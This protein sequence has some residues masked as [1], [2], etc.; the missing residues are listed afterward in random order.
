[1]I[2]LDSRAGEKEQILELLNHTINDSNLELECLIN[3]SD[4]RFNPSIKHNDFIS[5]LKRYKGRPDFE[6]KESVRLA[7]DFPENSKYKGVRVLVKGLGAVNSYCNNENINLIR[8]SVD[9]EMKTKPKFKNTRVTIPNYNIKFNLKLE[10]NFNN[11]DAKINELIRD[12]NTLPKNFR[13][14]KTFSFIQKTKD[15]QIDLSIV[16]SSTVIDRFMTV[17]D[18]LENNWL[19]YVTKPTDAK[20]SFINWWNSIKDKPTEQVMLKNAS[21]YHKTV[22]ESAV[23]TNVPKYEAEVEYIKNKEFNINKKK[24]NNIEERKAYLQ[25]EFVNFFKHIGSILQC[26]Q[27]S[28]NIISN[29][30]KVDIKKKFIKVVLDSAKVS[31]LEEEFKKSRFVEKNRFKNN[32]KSSNDEKKQQ[33]RKNIQVKLKSKKDSQSG[34]GGV[35]KGARGVETLVTINSDN[36]LEY[37]TET[38]DESDTKIYGGGTND[39]TDNITDDEQDNSILEGGAFHEN[40]GARGAEALVNKGARGAEAFANKLEELL[41]RKSIFFGPL[42]VD[43]T[44]NNAL[45]ID[46]SAIPDAKSNTNIHINYLVTD[47]TDGDR[48]L[49]F[50]DE[51]GNVYGI[52][53]E[54]GIKSFGCIM[55]SL[56]NS[57]LDGEYISRSEEDKVINNF[58]I[59]DSY[60]YKG[61]NVMHKPFLFNKTGGRHICMIEAAKYAS[62]GLNITQSNPRLPFILYKKDYLPSDSPRS[63]EKLRM[64]EGEIPLISENCSKLL[65]RMNVKYG[66]FLEVGHLYTYKT[67]GLVFLPNNLGIFQK[68]EDEYVKNPFIS[69]RWDNNYKWKPADHLTIDFKVEY[70]KEMETAKLAYKYFGDKKYLLVNLLSKVW[71]NKTNDNN[72][73]NFYLLNSGL[74]L[75]S[76][77]EDFKFFATNPFIGTYDSEGEFQNNMGEA[78]FEVDKNDNLVCENGDIITNGILCECAYDIDNER[79]NSNEQFRWKPQRIRADKTAA[80]A[81]GTANAAWSLINDPIT[82]EKLCCLKEKDNDK[83]NG[84]GKGDENNKGNETITIKEVNLETATYYTSNKNMEVLTAPLNDFASYVKRYLIERW[85][86]GYIKPKVMDL[87][88]G[89]LGD[90]DKYTRAEVHTLVGLDITE[91]GINNEKDGAA[92][93]MMNVSANNPA[94]AKLAEKTILLVGTSV[95]NIANGDCVRDNINKYYLDV[96]YGRAKGNTPKLKKMAGVALD[97]FDMITCMYAIHYMMNTESDLDSFLQN[98]SENLLDQG[99]FIGTCLDGMSILKEMGR[100]N[101]II[102]DIDGKTVFFIRKNDDD[103][104]YKDITVGNKI[105]VFYEK[106][107]GYFPENLVNI[108]YLKEK[109]KGHNLKLI[110]FRTFLEEPGN[111]LSQ[112]A[113]SNMKNERLI[114]QS[115]AMMTWAKFNC[116]FVFQK[117]RG[118]E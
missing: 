35:D 14:K 94:V 24:F 21:S 45:Q 90:L 10:Q 72:K 27:G 66:G 70:V 16:K 41:N 106:F 47:K 75:Q 105:T 67:D 85:L 29:S 79:L 15:F 88:V 57:I 87:A 34:G 13:Y 69:S 100:R 82:K 65:N 108:S 48:N 6:A 46:Q 118:K 1:M 40:K 96:L 54:N 3:N 62:S 68:S 110:E 22:K 73:L 5:I 52:D 8:N 53:R 104:A 99:Y 86:T 116:Y 17:K 61:E 50:F 63:Y 102:G 37:D 31:F 60:I 115:E 103:E 107:A 58:Y 111:L 55:P 44:H 101:E 74:K 18:V 26:I 32:D 23:F 20:T 25:G 59:F 76:I 64:D 4:D 112:Y 19:T 109:A 30:D 117:I 78:Y 77:P 95:K 97:G 113:A 98:V 39:T 56:A 92:T 81:Y 91:D 51:S 49:L 93:R 7:I 71:H 33:K 80:N 114:K 28:L 83:G 42:I 43:L 9:F 89:K 11:D 36:E 12:W 38:E 2:H 84:K